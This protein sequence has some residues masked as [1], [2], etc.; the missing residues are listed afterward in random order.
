MPRYKTPPKK[1]VTPTNNGQILILWENF[2]P[3]KLTHSSERE[4]EVVRFPSLHCLYIPRIFIQKFFVC[5]A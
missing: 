5:E 2:V 1:A 4:R 3:V